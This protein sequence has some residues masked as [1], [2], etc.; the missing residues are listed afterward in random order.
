VSFREVDAEYGWRR[1]DTAN[2]GAYRAVTC[3][4]GVKG[5][6]NSSSSVIALLVIAIGLNFRTTMPSSSE[7]VN[8]SSYRST[9]RSRLS[10]SACS[11]RLRLELASPWLYAGCSERLEVAPRA[12]LAHARGEQN[13]T[14]PCDEITRSCQLTPPAKPAAR[15]KRGQE[16][17]RANPS[18]SHRVGSSG[19]TRT[20]NPPVNSR[21]LCH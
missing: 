5:A 2:T 4:D 16:K 11:A 15:A 21:M 7:A 1:L 8:D 13:G 6:T 12:G 3:V 20:S 10:A 14:E 19:W 9:G 18:R 17:Q